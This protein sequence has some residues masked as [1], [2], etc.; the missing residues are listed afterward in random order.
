MVSKRKI[1]LIDPEKLEEAFK[2]LDSGRESLR[3]LRAK[4]GVSK[5]TLCY[6][7]ALRLEKKVEERKKVIAELEQRI[8]KLRTE[9]SGLESKY[10]ERSRL[11]EEDYQKKRAGLEGEIERLRKEA[12]TI[13][14][15]FEAY[16]IGWREGV[17]L[18]KQVRDLR[19]ERENLAKE[20][21]RLKSDHSYWRKMVN[22]LKSDYSML[23][24]ILN[25]KYGELDRLNSEIGFASTTLHA[26]KEEERKLVPL[27]AE[28]EKLKNTLKELESEIAV[29]KTEVEELE[30]RKRVITASIESEKAKAKEE[31][32]RLKKEADRVIKE[33]K[34]LAHE[35]VSEAKRRKEEELHELEQLRKEKE[36]LEAE[37][38]FLEKAIRIMLEE[39]RA[40]P[41]EEENYTR[42]E[43]PSLDSLR[44]SI[45]SLAKRY[46]AR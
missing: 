25:K 29:K 11:F 36:K 12:D 45:P 43:I 41:E 46:S 18:L 1:V 4:L 6:W 33:A 17:E 40:R 21:A 27:M 2:L 8:L 10:K 28:V 32:D 19:E 16:G 5:S 38:A 37:K 44:A 20:V 35:I 30:E 39:L 9:L 13:K 31:V 23:E 22:T 26:I 14:A 24:K 15:S 42:S 34:K 3:S 7:Y